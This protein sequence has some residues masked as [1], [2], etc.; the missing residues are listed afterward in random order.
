MVVSSLHKYATYAKYKTILLILTHAILICKCI[1][2]QDIIADIRIVL[3]SLL[4]FRPII[5]RT[6]EN[7]H[8]QYVWPAY[9]W[10]DWL[11]RTIRNYVAVAV[12]RRWHRNGLAEYTPG[13]RIF[14]APALPIKM[15][16]WRF[17]YDTSKLR[18]SV[19]HW[20]PYAIENN[21]M[22]IWQYIDM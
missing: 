11:L 5:Y 12:S 19:Q 7:L 21:P 8:G 14:S 22:Y 16:E 13:L 18:S 17:G 15:A 10:A 20:I 9:S 2:I 6:S 3:R 1:I 4:W